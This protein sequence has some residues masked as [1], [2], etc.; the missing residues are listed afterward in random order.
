MTWKPAIA[1]VGIVGMTTA[2]TVATVH[3]Q[4]GATKLLM[5][6]AKVDVVASYQ[7]DPLPKPDK[8]VVCAFTVSPDVVTVDQSAASLLQQKR[9]L[10]REA[11]R[12]PSK[13]ALARQVQAAFAKT[14]ISELQKKAMLAESAPA[15]GA[16]IP[17][18][19]LMVHGELTAINQG[20]Q[21]ERIMIGFGRGASDVQAHVTLSLIT[22][23]QPVVLS[24]FNL[25]SKSG[26]TPGAAATMGVGSLAV[27]AAAG[28]AGDRKASVEADASRMAKAV[29][30]QIKDVM[31]SQKW[32]PAQQPE[33][34]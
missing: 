5:G 25:K 33:G 16:E 19:T 22:D 15:S 1:L 29:A 10:R 8:I 17:A 27:G 23:A 13:E 30:K 20:N 9:L 3:A 2:F 6:D 32:I 28:G 31:I 21:T 26:K 7:G 12:G 24:E 4:S 14:L 11:D 34:R 18:H